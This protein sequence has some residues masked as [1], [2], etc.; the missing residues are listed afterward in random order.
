LK[1]DEYF[2]VV[3]KALVAAP[4]QGRARSI[5]KDLTSSFSQYNY[6]GSNSL[7]ATIQQS[8]S[9]VESVMSRDMLAHTTS[10]YQSRDY[11]IYSTK[12]LASLY[13]FPHWRFNRNPRISW[14]KFKIIPAPDTIPTSGLFL[15][16][17]SYGGI[18]KDI[19]VKQ[20][21]RFRHFY[22]IG[23]TGTGKST[24]METMII[25]DMRKGN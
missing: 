25:D 3:I 24:M 5:I 11:D 4:R 23:Q 13:H 12:E 9:F 10:R 18:N 16:T 14:Q 17:N 22:I 6:S 2:H 1:D 8:M 15:G 7:K 21:D 20:E 19:Y